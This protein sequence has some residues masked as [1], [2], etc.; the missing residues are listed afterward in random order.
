MSNH[1]RI[2]T[3]LVVASLFPSLAVRAD[4]SLDVNG[5]I[6]SRDAVVRYKRNGQVLAVASR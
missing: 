3:L 6:G 2:A 1:T 5:D 4:D